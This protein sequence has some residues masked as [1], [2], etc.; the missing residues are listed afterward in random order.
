AQLPDT[1]WGMKCLAISPDGKFVAGGKPDN[2]VWMFDVAKNA[3]IADSGRLDDLGGISAVAFTP[4]GDKLLAGGWKGKIQIWNVRDGAIV[5]DRD[6]VGHGKEL[7]F[8]QISSDGKYVLSGA[9]DERLRYWELA[10]SK[11]QFA[12]DGF[13]SGPK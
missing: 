1:K 9:R 12:W 5:I 4:Q 6:Y 11:E 13:K 2:A 10:T 3:K 8:V 7:L